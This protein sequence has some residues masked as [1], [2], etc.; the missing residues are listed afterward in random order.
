MRQSLGKARTGTECTFLYMSTGRRR[1]D[2]E[3]VHNLGCYKKIS[4][5]VDVRP[6]IGY[7]LGPLL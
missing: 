6:L 2:D 3:F 5:M 4:K 1:L 7:K